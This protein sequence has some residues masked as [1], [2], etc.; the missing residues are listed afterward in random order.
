MP[1]L[2]AEWHFGLV[3][4][5]WLLSA[6]YAGQFLGAFAFGPLAE[7]YGRLPVLIL[8]LALMSVL[9]I[10]CALTPTFQLLLALRFLQGLTIGGALPIAG[11]YISELAPA[12]IRGRYFTTFQVVTM[13]GYTIAAL[14]GIVVIPAL[15]WRWMFALGA[16]PLLLLPIV[17]LTLPESPRWLARRGRHD[18]ANRALVRLGGTPVPT[19]AGWQPPEADAKAERISPLALFEP[20]F[21]RATFTLLA[22]WLL[23]SITVFGIT[24]F[25]PT[26]YTNV[27]HVPLPTAL[28]Y[29]AISGFCYLGLSVIVGGLLDL[30]G[31]R[32][33][34]IACTGV[35][36]AAILTL[37]IA[38][39]MTPPV[40][41]VFLQLT[42]L[43]LSAMVSVNLW[44]YTAENFPTRVRATALGFFSSINRLPPIFVPVLIGTVLTATGSILPIYLLFATCAIVVLT[45]WILFGRETAGL[46]LEELEAR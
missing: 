36:V 1:A 45:V 13:S 44:P 38:N 25:G 10:L 27:Y 26:I 46:S 14:A 37:A 42:S 24:N 19:D 11:T 9:S 28:R 40:P 34:G 18:A 39:P 21:R 41:A 23:S 30:L 17:A 16:A 20:T 4:A 35:A 33:L 29:V 43:S 32:R 8:A 15:G 7:R 22:M 2:L 3:V 5:G 6:G 31:R 12:S